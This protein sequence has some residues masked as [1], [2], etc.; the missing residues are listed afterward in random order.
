MNRTNVNYIS[1]QNRSTNLVRI[2]LQ[3]KIKF[4]LKKE[5]WLARRSLGKGQVT[6]REKMFFRIAV[7]IDQTLEIV[8]LGFITI[9]IPGLVNL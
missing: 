3:P 1:R 8:T 6:K 9:L 5:A 2:V 4:S 7:L